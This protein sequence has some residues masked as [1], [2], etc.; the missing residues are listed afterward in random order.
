MAKIIRLLMIDQADL[1]TKAFELF[2]VTKLKVV[3][4]TQWHKVR[5]FMKGLTSL[6][7]AEVINIHVTLVQPRST[8][9]I[10]WKAANVW[11]N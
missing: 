2:F 5:R 4:L 7:D 8:H 3:S 6:T 9:R 11:A 1:E 10:C